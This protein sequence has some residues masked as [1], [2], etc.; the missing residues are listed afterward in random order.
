MEVEVL[1]AEIDL[2]D[3]GRDDQLLHDDWVVLG[4]ECFAAELPEAPRSLPDG[5]RAAVGALSGPDRTL[6][7][8]SLEVA[9][10]DRANS[11]RALGRLS[12][13]D[14]AAILEA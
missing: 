12:D 2:E 6:S 3:D 7:A 8:E 11:R 4:D 14:V 1:V 5:V 10:L 13:D 9:V